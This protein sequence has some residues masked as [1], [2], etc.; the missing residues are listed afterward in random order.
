MQLQWLLASPSPSQGLRPSP[1]LREGTRQALLG[2][3]SQRYDSLAPPTAMST[4][5]QPTPD[6]YNYAS[7]CKEEGAPP[8]PAFLLGSWLSSHPP[9]LSLRSGPS[10]HGCLY[11]AKG[12]L[13]SHAGDTPSRHPPISPGPPGWRRPPSPRPPVSKRGKQRYRPV[14]LHCVL[15]CSARLRPAQRWSPSTGF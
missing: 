7:L 6:P 11:Q 8:S 15:R 13:A 9:Q 12:A 4:R 5:A 3:P 1:G 14:P 10:T 2:S